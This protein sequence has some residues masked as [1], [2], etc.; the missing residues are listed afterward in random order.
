MGLIL[1]VA[2]AFSEADLIR[3][4]CKESLFE[5]VKEFW[6]VI[7]PQKPVYNWH[8]PFLCDE[9]QIVAERIFAGLPKQYDLAINVPPGSTK[10]TIC[11]IMLPAWMWTRMPTARVISITYAHLLALDHSRKSRILI[12]SPEYQAVFPTTFSE[13]QDAKGFYV[14]SKGGFR[15]AAGADGTIGGMHGHI[16]LVDDPLNPKE[17]ASPAAIASANNLMDETVPNRKVDKTT[18]PT[19]LIMQRLNQDDPTGH[20]LTQSLAGG[21]K[22]RHICL[23]AEETDM[24]RP[25][26]LRERYIDGLLDPVRLPRSVLAEIK[27][28]GEFGYAGQYLQ[29]PVPLGGGM[30]KTDR[31][32][33]DTPPQL[34]NFVSLVRYWDK[35]GSYGKGCYT[36]G[37]LMGVD[38]QGH[39][40]VLDVIRGQWDSAMRES[41]IKA[42]AEMDGR[43][44]EIW[45]EQEPGSGGK[46]SAENTV[47]NLPGYTVHMDRPSGD[48]VAR[49]DPYSSQVNAGCVYL[50]KGSPWIPDYIGELRYFPASTYK[51]QVDAS[52][53]AFAAIYQPVIKVGAL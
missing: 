36:V 42:T 43:Q 49:A 26:Y 11:S 6:P 32:I 27:S 44:V 1:M 29:S 20:I 47:R 15:M 4:I 2:P 23:P 28:K 40:W 25:A 33:V 22:V 24:I 50:K 48:K 7:I 18:C 16:V 30:F 39:I 14:N 10:S 12:K 31:F 3:S 9:L 41:V 34:M 52:S 5:F 17:T 53:G 19:V 37:I 46:E 38:R 13:D 8:I 21:M 45:V 51:D 35:A